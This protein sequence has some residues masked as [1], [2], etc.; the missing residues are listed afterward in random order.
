MPDY[1]VS[2][3][4][5]GDVTN[6]SVDYY[7]MEWEITGGQEEPSALERAR[8]DCGCGKTAAPAARAVPARCGNNLPQQTDDAGGYEIVSE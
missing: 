8:S 7:P 6:G 1:S 3:P 2:R 4:G 5:A